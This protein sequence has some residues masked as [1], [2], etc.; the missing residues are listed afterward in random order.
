LPWESKASRKVVRDTGGLPPAVSPT[1]WKVAPSS[2]E[3]YTPVPA[4][5][6]CETLASPV[7]IHN[8]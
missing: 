4:Q 5:L 1:R 3:R 6:S 2:E 7:P 8:E